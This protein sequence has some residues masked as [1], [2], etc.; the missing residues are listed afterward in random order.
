[1]LTPS[2]EPACSLLFKDEAGCAEWLTQLQLTNQQRAQRL[3]LAQ[4][5]ELNRCPMQ[6][7]ERLNILERMRETIHDVQFDYAR[8][9]IAKPLP[10]DQ[11]ELTVFAA[12]VQL[13][14]A[15]VTGYQRCLQN[16]MNGD[17]QL[18]QQGALLCYRCLQ[19]GG[20]AIF[21]HLRTGYEFD[22]TLWQPLHKL[23]S[24]AE[25]R[26]LLREP[27]S[28]KLNV[29]QPLS[30]CHDIYIKTLLA[31]YAHPAELN[32]TQ[33]QQLDNWLAQW[34]SSVNLG[35][36]YT[37]SKGDAQ[38]LVADLN[39]SHGLRPVKLYARSAHTSSMRYLAMMPLSKLLR[40]KTILLQQGNSPQQ[41]ELGGLERE[42]CI[43]FLTFLHRCWC[44]N[45]NTRYEARNS[46]TVKVQLIRTTEIIHAHL[47]VEIPGERA[48][49]IE[50]WQVQNDSLAGAQL[51]CED[52]PRGR[53]GINQLIALHAPGA[54]TYKLGK[55]AWVSVT[56][57]GRLRIGMRYFPGSLHA[58]VLCGSGTDTPESGQ[59]IPAL[60]LE[61]ALAFNA[62]PSLIVPRG[63]FKAG[64][65]VD[66]RYQNGEM[67][68]AKMRFSV[69]RGT[70]FERVSFT[71]M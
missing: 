18:V 4:V 33:L 68:S 37:T 60:L 42:D 66:I 40:V 56:Q 59:Q 30:C 71:L 3:L 58:I 17:S 21:E 70:D 51:T 41:L 53:W 31:C 39:S 43:D 26:K 57:N 11:S 28:D 49:P 34:S 38:P 29:V 8:K 1:M 20:L 14:Q 46:S 64:L 67:K 23:Y 12:I 63:W 2:L 52:T 54:G 55:T 13:W 19:Y 45:L 15:L 10:L 65:V 36:T 47:S 16:C 35:L 69:E 27:V 32:R 24:F 6:G 25:Q 22:G 48:A 9:L 61:A 7:L 5:N 50:I 44:E 62:P